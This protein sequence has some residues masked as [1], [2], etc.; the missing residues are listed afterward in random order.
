MTDVIYKALSKGMTERQRDLLDELLSSLNNETVELCRFY[1]R[2]GLRA[3]LTNLKFLNEI[4]D[5]EYLI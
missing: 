5:I 4:D 3:G 1:F 2:E